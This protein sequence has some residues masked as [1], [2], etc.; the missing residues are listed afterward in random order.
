MKNRLVVVP[1]KRRQVTTCPGFEKKN[2]AHSHLELS[3]LCGFGCSYCSSNA[4]NYL[5]IRRE[6]FAQQTERQLGVKTYPADDPSLMFVWPTVIDDLER[7]LRER[8]P[9][10]GRGKTLVVSMLTDAFAPPLET[11]G[12]TRRALDLVLELTDFRVR[13]LTK[14]AAVGSTRWVDFFALH[15]ERF[16]V[17]LSTGML[18]DHWAASVEQGTSLPSARLRALRRLQDAGVPTYG[19]LC[20]IFP[21]QIDDDRVEQL[22]DRV[23]PELVEHIWVEPFNDR[24]NWQRVRAGFARD[25]AAHAWLTDVYERRNKPA[26]SS[27]ATNLYVRLRDK[28]RRE[29]WGHKLRYLLYE[30]DISEADAQALAGFAGIL[31]QSKPAADGRS[32][33][34]HIAALQAA[35]K[36]ARP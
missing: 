33:N 28:A 6:E 32:R 9:G 4:G 34:R 19:M 1:G 20:P 18:D 21:D 13:I 36:A 2:L 14:S 29:G 10:Y 12:V 17:G 26:W 23:R 22:V 27:Y 7:E 25:S 15:A 5:R 31:L 35:G 3:A 30:R 11:A 8:R 16:V 24:A